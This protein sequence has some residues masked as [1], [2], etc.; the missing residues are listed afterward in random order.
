MIMVESMVASQ[1]RDEIEKR[2]AENRDIWQEKCALLM[3]PVQLSLCRRRFHR[4]TF[5]FFPFLKFFFHRLIHPIPQC[6]LRSRESRAKTAVI[7]AKKDEKK[8]GAKETTKRNAA[9][10]YTHS[11]QDLSRSCVCVSV[12]V[13]ACTRGTECPVGRIGISLPR[14]GREDTVQHVPIGGALNVAE[15]ISL[16]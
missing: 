10:P 2:C 9:T 14:A 4:H 16:S 15:Q 1:Q 6:L 5:S 7:A 3:G 11:R 12:C 8:A 13:C